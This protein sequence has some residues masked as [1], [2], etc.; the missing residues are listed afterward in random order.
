MEQY[1]ATEPKRNDQMRLVNILDHVVVVAKH[2][3][4]IAK[5]VGAAVVVSAVLLFLVLP[6]WYKSTAVVMPPKQK[7]TLGLLSSIS[8]VASPLRGL[9]LGGVSDD[10]AQ[11]QTIVSSRTVM[12]A[13]VNRFDLMKVYDRETM[14]KAIKDLESN[15]TF[16]IGKE[17]VSLELSVLDTEPVRAAEMANFFVQTL[18]KVY[19]EM[20]VTE[21]K[22]NREFLEKRYHQ[23]LNDLKSA[24]EAFKLFQEKYNVYS[25]PDQVKAAVEAAATL[26][27]RIALKEV[28]LGL[29]EATTTAE[30]P[31]RQNIEAEIRELRKQVMLM[32]Q[33]SSDKKKK[34][35]VFA[36][37]QQVPEI[38]IEYIRHFREVELQGKILELILPLYEQAKIE[39][40]R[41]TPSV[42]VLD[43]AVPAVRHSKPKRLIILTLVTFGS[44]AIA[45]LIALYL[46]SFRRSKPLRTLEDDAKLAFVRNELA[47]KNLFRRGEPATRDHHLS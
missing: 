19:L 20:S 44:L 47:I 39:E 8:R 18:N 5:F 45:Y 23:N 33:G 24:E 29:I 30:N 31:T 1:E 34:S 4:F 14:E 28:Q 41:N 3:R 25:V 35:L 38:G 27:S 36:P 42:I 26:E 37:F 11:L 9:G 43:N 21:A 7:N 32:R 10:L 17:D 22:G 15:V 40:Q 46:E 13:V 6:R 16:S 12:E 2:K